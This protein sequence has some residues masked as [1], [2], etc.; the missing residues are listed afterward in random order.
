MMSRSKLYAIVSAVLALTQ[1]GQS[2][3]AQFPCPDP[4]WLPGEGLP[5]TDG[6]VYATAMWDPDGPGPKSPLLVVGG[7]FAVAGDVVASNIAVYDPVTGAWSALGS[8]TNNIVWALTALPNGD[9]VAGGDFTTAGGVSANYIA[10]WNGSA[11]SALGTGM[12]GSVSELTTLSNEDLVAGGQFTIAGGNVSYWFA[13]Y[14]CPKPPACYADCDANSQLNIDD[15]ICFQTLYAL[16]D[17]L[18]DCDA[19]GTLTID[20]FFCFQ[21]AFAVGC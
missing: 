3:W 10:R 12:N 20:D 8:G 5:G 21:T 17:P 4:Q 11:W 14:G 7:N 6:Q 19:D 16:G 1:T 18:A 15:F 2:V 9:L 13:R